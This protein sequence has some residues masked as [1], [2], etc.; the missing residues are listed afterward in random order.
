MLRLL[1]SVIAAGE[2]GEPV[3]AVLQSRDPDAPPFAYVQGGGGLFKDMGETRETKLCVHDLY[4]VGCL[5]DG[6]S[7]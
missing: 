7:R 5:I 4:T 1:Q 3:S 2:V 6:V